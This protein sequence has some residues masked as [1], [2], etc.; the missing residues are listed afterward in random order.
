M[1]TTLGNQ[2]TVQSS[3]LLVKR[4]LVLKTTK[5]MWRAW[6]QCVARAALFIATFWL[7]PQ[8]ANAAPKLGAPAPEFEI[9]A[10]DGTPYSNNSLLGKIVVFESFNLDC[11]YSA[12]HYKSGAMQELQE[13]FTE[14]GVVWLTVN[15]THQDHVSY[16]APEKAIEDIESLRMKSTDYINDPTSQLSLTLG[17]RVTPQFVILDREGETV[18]TGAIDDRPKPFG[19]PR[20]AQNYVKE[21]LNALLKNKPIPTPKTRP[22]GCSVKF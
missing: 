7:Q 8:E 9:V 19:D 13:R 11:P 18:Y 20:Q 17:F 14:Q 5:S 21:A 2:G 10:I 15:G 1:V 16:Q 4:S 6:T 3:V 12:N 22:Y